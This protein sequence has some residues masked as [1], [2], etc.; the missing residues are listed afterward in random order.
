MPLDKLYPPI[1]YPVS[2]GTPKISSLLRWDHSASL[3]VSKFETKTPESGE[4]RFVI[5]SANKD[6]AYLSGHLIDGML[7]Y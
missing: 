2:R 4:R 3:F 6:Y 5:N 7:Y 1:D